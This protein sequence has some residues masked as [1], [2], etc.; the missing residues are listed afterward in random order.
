MSWGGTGVV[1]LDLNQ[2]RQTLVKHQYLDPAIGT[3]CGGFVSGQICNLGIYPYVM[4]D[5]VETPMTFPYDR[6]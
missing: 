6:G 1:D 5:R 3:T 2:S 4:C